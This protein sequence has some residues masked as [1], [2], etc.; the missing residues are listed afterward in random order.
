M[1]MSLCHRLSLLYCHDK[2]DVTINGFHFWAVT[3][4]LKSLHVSGF[5]CCAVTVLLLLLHFLDCRCYMI[6]THSC[7]VTMLLILLHL[8]GC[9]CCTVTEIAMS[10]HIIGCHCHMIINHGCAVTM[11]LM[12]LTIIDCCCE[13]ITTHYCTVTVIP[14]SLHIIDLHCGTVMIT[15]FHWFC[16]TPWGTC[17]WKTTVPVETV[18][19]SSTFNRIQAFCTSGAHSPVL[20][21]KII[22]CVADTFVFKSFIKNE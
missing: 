6:F 11:L 1:L 17:C 18:S 16:R 21:H 22:L 7:A 8:I 5:Y 14:M 12:L 10:L 15:T 4:I 13:M 20:C 9:L 19:I 2:P 3:V